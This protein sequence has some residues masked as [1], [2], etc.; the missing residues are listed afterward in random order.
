EG[1][2]GGAGGGG[3]GSGTVR[4][5]RRWEESRQGGAAILPAA[6]PGVAYSLSTGS[7]MRIS[8]VLS[9]LTFSFFMNTWKR[10][11]WRRELKLASKCSPFGSAP[12]SRACS[13]HW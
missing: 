4:N 11:S 1:G 5:G 13:I 12:S 8:R 6:R 2:G 3:A 9:I 7:S 10:G